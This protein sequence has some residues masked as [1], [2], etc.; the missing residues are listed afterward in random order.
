MAS[1]DGKNPEKFFGY[2]P[3]ELKWWHSLVVLRLWLWNPRHPGN[4]QKPCAFDSRSQTMKSKTH[5]YRTIF[6]VAFYWLFATGAVWME[7][8]WGKEYA[9]L[10]PR[11]KDQER[12]NTN[13]R[14][15]GDCWWAHIR[16]QIYRL[17]DGLF[18]DHRDCV[19]GTQWAKQHT[20]MSLLG[21]SPITISRLSTPIDSR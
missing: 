18:R 21:I 10:L 5:R 6:R 15:T 3:I 11:T 20:N 7:R 16:H 19:T 12:S 2:F 4:I 14:F 13:V 17:I 1:I 9:A 8:W